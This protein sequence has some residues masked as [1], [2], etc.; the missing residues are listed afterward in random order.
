MAAVRAMFEEMARKDGDAWISPWA[1]DGSR[2]LIPYS[3]EGFPRIAEGKETL[4]PVY[5]DLF[6][7]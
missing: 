1:D 7:G 3:P 6:G 4:R 2:Q 5:R